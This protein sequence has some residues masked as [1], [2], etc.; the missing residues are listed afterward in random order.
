M[1]A[2]ILFAAIVLVEVVASQASA[3][4]VFGKATP[5]GAGANTP[6]YS[7]PNLSTG[8]TIHWSR[9]LFEWMP[10]FRENTNRPGTLTGFPDPDKNTKA[11]LQGF[12]YRRLR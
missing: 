1:R 2:M 8:D 9:R 5:M 4:G 12:G 7:R 6:N 11:Y 10:G 3:Q